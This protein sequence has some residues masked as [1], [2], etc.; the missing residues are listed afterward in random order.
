MLSR[1][2]PFPIADIEAIG[3]S[4]NGN[5]HNLLL[6]SNGTDC[7][8][9]TKWILN[10]F[11]DCVDSSLKMLGFSVGLIS[12]FLW[13]VPL[14]PQLYENY[15]QKR[16]EGLS[17]F[18]LMFWLIGD[19]C[20]LLGALLTHQQ[21]LQ[22]WIGFYYIIQDMV[23][24]GQF[25]YYTRIYSNTIGE[26]TRTDT[27]VIIPASILGFFGIFSF[28]ADRSYSSNLHTGRSLSSESIPLVTQRGTHLMF[29]PIFEGY[30]DV[31]GY[32][33][34]TVAAFCY[35]AGRIPQLLR[36]YYRKSCEGL[37]LA[38]FYI[39]VLA[40][41]TYGLSVLLETTGWRY[42]LRHLPWLAGSLGCCAF[43]VIMI[44]QIYYYNKKNSATT[45]TDEREELLQDE[46]ED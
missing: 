32:L 40:N 5:H 45:I 22:Q 15:K 42:L 26:S 37:S 2:W 14:F 34:G 19:T 1:Y 3:M 43:D 11:G 18:F 46:L 29:P 41:F 16:C 38:M 35:F 23:L 13:L 10:V 21:P 7:P 24:V 25:F 28:I 12:L 8:N 6:D 39:I 27:A 44:G 36:N 17:I 9:G 4:H 31:A 30:K 20:N 33:I